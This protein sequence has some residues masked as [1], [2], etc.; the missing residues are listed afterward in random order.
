[1]NEE[2]KA[3]LKELGVSEAAITTL[4]GQELTTEEALKKG[5]TYDQFLGMGIKA[6]SATVL[7]ATYAPEPAIA[8]P[9]SAS[10]FT[11]DMSTPNIDILPS[12]PESDN[13]F[14]EMLKVGGVLKITPGDVIS[15]VKAAIAKKVGIYDL[16]DLLRDKMEHFAKEQGEPVGQSFYDL[17]NLITTR[18]YADVLS[19]LGVSG[20]FI[21]ERRKNDVLDRLD[22]Y[23]WPALRSFD[24]TLVSWCDAWNKGAN[25]MGMV[26]FLVASGR[27]G[28]MPP[29]LMQ[30]PDTATL[31]DEAETVINKINKV[32]AGVGIPV[33]RALAYDAVRIRKILEEPT[34]PSALGAA[35]REQM[36]KSLGVDVSAA[37]IRLERNISRY[38]MSIMNYPTVTSGNEDY[39]YLTA[40]YLLGSTIREKL[41]TLSATP[42][43]PPR[44]SKKE[45]APIPGN[46]FR[47]S[48]GDVE[49]QP[50]TRRAQP[51]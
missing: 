27:G 42:S 33:A 2:L 3:K 41:I 47:K 22:E 35:T 11:P 34:L 36:L 48:E 8:A 50:V 30:P 18:N 38:A 37:D 21:S 6:A 9:A 43:R 15:A 14:L 23:L 5:Y 1:M 51:Y 31:R 7:A 20:S 10:G 16:P 45:E 19:I 13:S 46:G 12:V 4:E 49:M 44:S 29:G 25:P 32:F 26:G 24:D 17:N 28:P 40:M 39:A